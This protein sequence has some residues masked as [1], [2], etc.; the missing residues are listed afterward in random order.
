[1]SNRYSNIVKDF[2]KFTLDVVY[3]INPNNVIYIGDVLSDL[4]GLSEHPSCFSADDKDY[5]V[6]YAFLDVYHAIAKYNAYRAKY[7][8]QDVEL[9]NA[10][11]NWY[12]VTQ[13]KPNI[14]SKIIQR[15][16]Q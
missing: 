3:E 15:I 14:F 7:N 2:Y 12:A 11:K 16:K 9:E 10:L 5:R 1:M 4:K 6:Y 8:A 13:K